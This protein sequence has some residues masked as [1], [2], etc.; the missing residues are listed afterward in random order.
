AEKLMRLLI[1]QD[2]VLVSLEEFE[3]SQKEDKGCRMEDDDDPNNPLGFVCKGKCSGIAQ[4][5]HVIL[6]VD[7]GGDII[8]GCTCRNPK[9]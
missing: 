7:D 6:T 8:G 9:P 2:A 4:R 3:E 5:C 1:N